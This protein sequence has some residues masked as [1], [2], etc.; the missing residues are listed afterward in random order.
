MDNRSAH[1]PQTLDLGTT[2]RKRV[3][4]FKLESDVTSKIVSLRMFGLAWSI[5]PPC[6]CHR[7]SLIWV[8]WIVLFAV[9]K[10]C[11]R[12]SFVVCWPEIHQ[13][14]SILLQFV[15]IEIQLI[16]ELPLVIS[17]CRTDKFSRSF[18]PSDVRLCNFLPSDTVS[19]DTL[20]SF[21]SAMNLCLLRD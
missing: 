15:I 5:V 14:Q 11:V 12:V 21:K 17:R 20:S 9:R 19:G 10:G 6:R 1:D 2:S 16:F 3:L 18:L 8:Y 4:N 13:I 7:Q